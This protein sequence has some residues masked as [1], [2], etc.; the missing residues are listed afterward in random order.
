MCT[1]RQ[2]VLKVHQLAELRA[3]AKE[4]NDRMK[5]LEDDIKDTMGDAETYK[6]KNNKLKCFCPWR[7]RHSLDS[8]R[9]K[10]EAPD[11]YSQYTKE[12]RY[13]GQLT[14]KEA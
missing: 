2:L 14:W 3:L 4:V 13:R 7:T 10:A 1:D 8:Q 12:T 6:T 11:V 9:L 5:V